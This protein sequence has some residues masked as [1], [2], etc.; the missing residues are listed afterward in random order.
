[1]A[2][3]SPSPHKNCPPPP[4]WLAPHIMTLKPPF[5]LAA[6]PSPIYS[7]LVG[8]IPPFVKH[9]ALRITTYNI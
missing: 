4:L 6:P 5:H 7:F 2:Q 1:M 9:L 3:H 8:L